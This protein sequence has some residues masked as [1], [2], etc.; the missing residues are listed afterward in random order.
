LGEKIPFATLLAGK[1]ADGSDARQEKNLF[2]ND[3]FFDRRRKTETL[4]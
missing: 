1:K 3:N 4:G 2:N